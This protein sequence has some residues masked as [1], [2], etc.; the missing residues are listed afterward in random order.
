MLGANYFDCKT[1]KRS[2]DDACVHNL[3]TSHGNPFY[4]IFFKVWKK[5]V[6]SSGERMKSAFVEGGGKKERMV[7]N[8]GGAAKGKIPPLSVLDHFRCR[9]GGCD[10]VPSLRAVSNVF[11]P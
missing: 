1:L 8:K 5:V 9:E 2:L 10:K 7:E 11:M 4:F 6:V 3:Q